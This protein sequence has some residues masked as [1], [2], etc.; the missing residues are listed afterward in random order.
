MTDGER[1]VAC[2]GLRWWISARSG[3]AEVHVKAPDGRFAQMG[4]CHVGIRVVSC[5]T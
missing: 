2:F 1:L 3:D 5:L 4:E